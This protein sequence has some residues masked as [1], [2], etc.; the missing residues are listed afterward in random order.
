MLLGSPSLRHV[1][2]D[3]GWAR[4]AVD[5]QLCIGC[6]LCEVRAPENMEVAPGESHARVYKQPGDAAEQAA[7]GEACDYCPTGGLQR[8]MAPGVAGAHE[9]LNPQESRP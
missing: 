6:G 9:E 1:S 3:T 5:E 8:V 2:R 4:F 7:C